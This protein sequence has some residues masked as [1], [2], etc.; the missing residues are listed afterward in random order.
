MNEYLYWN[1]KLKIVRYPGNIVNVSMDTNKN[2]RHIMKKDIQEY[3]VNETAVEIMRLINGRNTYD[4]VVKALCDKYGGEHSAIKKKLDDFIKMISKQYGLNIVTQN[5]PIERNIVEM[6]KDV[7][8]P[9]VASIEI[10]NKCNIRCV[11]CYGDFGEIPCEVMDL[12]VVKKILSDLRSIGV[13]IIEITGGEATTHP[14]I[15]EIIEYALGLGFEQVSLLTNGVK[16]SDRLIQILERSK[17]RVYVQIDLHSLREEYFSWFTKTPNVLEKVKHNIVML[18]EKGILMRVATILTPKN[19]DE[20]VDIADWVHN[21]GIARYAVSPVVSLGRA[22][23][24]DKELYLDV[25]DAMK[26]EEQLQKIVAKYDN[27]LNIITSDFNK[28]IN[29]GCITSHIVI[30]SK[31]CIKICTM[32]NLSYCNGSIGNIVEENIK[33]IFEKNVELLNILYTTKAPKFNSDE[34]RS[35][36]NAGFC[37]G[38]LLRGIIKAK[39]MKDECLWYKNIVPQIIKE[40]FAFEEGI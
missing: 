17:E 29:C 4:D 37:N 40:R 21:L 22:N 13:R 14:K 19:I 27:F 23:S 18:A 32:D 3:R 8:S 9:M 11:H 35:C 12:E 1:Y 2:N 20:L 10:T 6:N 36:E 15:E 26:A 31:G 5:E 34:C 24:K 25:N 39:E 7:V 16:I 30:D 28:Q 33:S 38:C